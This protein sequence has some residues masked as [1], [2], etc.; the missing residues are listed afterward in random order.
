MAEYYARWKDGYASNKP[1]INAARKDAINYLKS[2]W[3]DRVAIMMETK[4][5]IKGV[6][7]VYR[8]NGGFRYYDRKRRTYYILHEW[9]GS[10]GSATERKA[11]PFG[12]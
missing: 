7:D 5:N 6:G 9:D 1:T 11:S 10:I 8:R 2:H 12:L 3:D 4:D